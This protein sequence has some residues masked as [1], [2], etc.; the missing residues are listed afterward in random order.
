M[1]EISKPL[2]IIEIF[3]GGF[4]RFVYLLFSKSLKYLEVCLSNKFSGF[5]ANLIV[6]QSIICPEIKCIPQCS[7]LRLNVKNER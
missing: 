7:Y 3:I 5:I 6:C 4:Q 1:Q 2:Q